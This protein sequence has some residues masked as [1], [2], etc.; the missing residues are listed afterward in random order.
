MAKTI[1]ELM[2]KSYNAPTKGKTIQELMGNAAATYTQTETTDT[3]Y[4]K[5]GLLNGVGYTLGKI[6]T[7]AFSILEG[8]WDYTAGGVA[9]IF[10]ADEWAEKQFANN[11]AAGWNQD[12]DE[13]YNPSNTMRIVGDVASGVGNSAVGLLAIAGATA[14]SGGALTAPVAGAI[15]GGVMGVGAAG[16]ATSEAYAKT[17]KLGFKEYGYG[18]LSGATEGALEGITGAAGKVGA[19]LFAKQTAKTVAK[20]TVIKGLLSDFAGEAV[21]EGLS[22]FITPYY[23]RWTQVDPNA[24]KATIQQI[25]Y[26]AL[27]GGL[28]GALMGGVGTG[29]NTVRAMSRGNEISKNKEY[30]NTVVNMAE[31][32]A[33]YEADNQTGKEAYQYVSRLVEDYKAKDN[34][35]GIL[36]LPQ[37]RILG[38]MERANAVLTFEPEIQASKDKIIADADRFAEYINSRNLVDNAGNPIN[39][40]SGADLI[41]NE[42]VLTQFAVAD[43]LG[44]LMLTPETFYS[45]VSQNRTEDVLQ[46]DFR[47]FQKN[48][49]PQ[50]KKAINEMFGVDIDSVSYEDFIAAMQKTNRDT[51]DSVQ[52]GMA[53]RASS[54][55]AFSRVNST[56]ESVGA[57]NK[58]VELKDGTS[59]YK[60]ADGKLYAVSKS[61]NNYYVYDGTNISKKLTKQ[62]LFKVVDALNGVTETT[63]ENA[64][65]QAVTQ[66]VENVSTE[67]ENTQESAKEAQKTTPTQT[68]ETK[69]ETKE[70]LKA[71]TPTKED[72]KATLAKD[73]VTHMRTL[74]KEKGGWYTKDVTNYIAEHNELDFIERIYANDPAVKKDLAGFLSAVNDVDTLEGMAWY[75]G[76]AFSDKGRTWSRTT[77]KSTYPYRGAVRTFKNAISKR[78][79]EVATG[80]NLGIQNGE[81]SLNDI[82]KLF[83]QL[84]KNP[85]IA[86]FAEKVFA[87]VERLGVNI[88]FVNATLSTRSNVAGDNAGDMVEYKTSYFNDTTV[89]D[90]KKAGTLLH[91]LVH[92]CTSY[93]MYKYADITANVASIDGRDANYVKIVNCVTRLNQIY[94]QISKDADFKDQYG[95]TNAKEMVAELANEE[96][97]GLMKKKNLWDRILDAICNLFGFTR[98]NTAYD[99]AMQCLEYILDNP[100]VYAYKDYAT[101]QR[102]KLVRSGRNTFGFTSAVSERMT[103]TEMRDTLAK[104]FDIS[105]NLG[106]KETHKKDL[107]KSYDAKNST[108]SY[109]DILGKYDKILNIWKKLGG[110]LNSK[111]LEEWDNKQGKDRTFTVFKEQAGY[112]YNIELSSM[113]KKGVPLFEAID[114]IVK[115]EV[116]KELNLKTIGKAEKEILY[117][118]LKS[119]HFEIP[120][121]ICYVEQARQREGTIIESFLDGKKETTK[122]GAVKSFKLGWNE[123]INNVQA[124]M[125]KNGVDYTFPAVDRSISTDN[126]TAQ[127][128][129]MDEATQTAFYNA[130]Q[131]LANEEIA[132][133]NKAEGKNKPLIKTVTPD[134]IKASLGGNVGSN[135]KI[136]RV[137]FQNPDS[138]FTI[139]KDL[140]YSS[141]TTLNLASS[142]NALYSLFNSQGGVAGYK[143]KQTPIVYWG[144][145]LKKTWE[146]GK[147][148]KVGGIRNQSNSDFQMYTL[149][150]QAQMYIDFTAKGYYLQAYTKVLSELKLFGLS[151][152]KINASL[153]PRV[154]AYKLANGEVDI[155]RTMATA[156]LDENGNPIY[157]DIEGIP[158]EEAFMLIDDGDYSK[159]ITGICIG[160]SDAHIEKLLDDNRV[161]LIIGFHDKTND[162]T[163]RYRGARYAKNYNGL[164]EAINN[165]T[166]KTVHI[167]FNQ[168]VQKAEKMFKYDVET[169]TAEKNMLYHNGKLYKVDNIPNLAAD[170]YLEMCKEKN[171]TPAYKDFAGHENYYKLLA[172]FG[173][174]DSKGHYAPHKKVAYNMPERVP[175]LDAN[176]Q[177][178][179]V[180]TE[181]YIKQELE[182]ELAVRDSIAQALSDTSANGIIPQFKQRVQELQADVSEQETGKD[183]KKKRNLD[184]EYFDKLI[185][186]LSWEDILGE[187]DLELYG[188]KSMSVEDTSAELKANPKKAEIYIRRTGLGK[189][190]IKDGK[191]A[192][193]KQSRIDD[194][195]EDSGAQ[196]HKTYARSYI[197]RISPKDFID[198]T[199]NQDHLDRE[200]FDKGV[201]GDHGGL[202][203]DWD[204]EK[205]L[206]DSRQSPYLHIDK[207]TGRIIGHNGR[208]RIRALEKAG[209]KAV[210]IE[211]QFYDEDGSLIKYDAETLPDV[212]ISSQFNT[213]I[214]THLYDVIP[215]NETHRA[216]I[217]STYGENANNNAEISYQERSNTKKKADLI[218]NY[219]EKQYNDFGWARANNVLTARENRNFV[220]KYGEIK[221]GQQVTVH[222]T[223][224]GEIIVETN[225]MAKDKFGVNNVLVFA[226]GDYENYQINKVIRLNLNDETSLEIVRGFIYESK[227]IV[228]ASYFDGVLEIY[229]AKDF[230]LGTQ[231]ER[232]GASFKYVETIQDGA[233]NTSSVKES[234]GLKSIDKDYLSA[235]NNG[236]MKIADRM[237]EEA[238][239]KAGYTIKAYHGSR[240]VFNAFDKTKLGSN[241]KTETSKRWFFAADKKTANSYYPY[242]VMQE[243]AKKYS[244]AKPEEVKEKG[245]LY[246]LY[247][248]MENPLTVD[249]KDYDYAAHHDKADA[250]MEFVEQAE[251]DGNDGIILLNAMDNQLDTSARESTVYMFKEPSQAKSADTVTYDENGNII[252]LSKRFDSDKPEISYQETPIKGVDNVKKQSNDSVYGF[253]KYSET[254]YSDRDSAGNQLTKEQQEFFKDSKVR[255][256]KGRLQVVYHGTTSEFNTFKRGDIG[257]HF[258][259]YAQARNR[260]SYQ[261]GKKRYIKAYLD[262]KNPLVVEHDSGS[263]HGNYAAGM[264]LTWG[265]FN[266]NP[267]AVERL[268]EIARMYDTRKSDVE[269]KSFLKSL[270]YDGVQY[271]NTH[272]SDFGKESY[273]Y[274]AFDSNQVKAVTNLNPTSD[275]DINYDI[276]GSDKVMTDLPKSKLTLQDVVLGKANKEDLV[277]QVKGNVSETTEA[278]KVL[279]TNA[280]AALERV[281]KEIGVKDATARTN[282]IRAGKYAAQNA[283]EVEGAQYNLY[284]DK[285]VGESLGKI[286]KPIYEADAKD[287]KTFADFEL[288]LLHWHNTDRYEAGKPVFNEWDDPIEQH[289]TSE[290]SRQA[291]AELEKKYPQF[292]KIAEK[293]WKF[294]DNNLQL[295]VDSG[296]YSQEYADN[297][298]E[299]YPHYVP[300]PREEYTTKAAALMGKNNL[301]VNNAKKGAKGSSARV[302][303]IDDTMSAQT[304]QKTTSARINSLLVT[305]LENGKSD[306]FQVIESEDADIDIDTETEVTFHKDEAKNTHQVSF[307]YNGKKVTAQVSRLVFKGIE[308]FRPSSGMSDNVAIAAV[309][310]VNSTF[311]KLVTSL[312]PFFSFF[313]NPVRDMQDALLYT[314]YSPL[315]FIKNYDRARKEIKTNGKYWQEAKAAGISAASVYD[316]EKG[317]EYKQNDSIS[318]AKRLKQKLESASNSIEMSPRLAEYISAREAGLSVQEALLQAQDVTTNFG[319]GGTFAKTLNSTV[320]PFLNPSIQ[321]FSKMVRSYMG[322]NGKKEWVALIIKSLI[323]G[324]GATALNDLMNDDDEEY[325]GLSDYVKEQNYL[326]GLGDGDFLKL[327]KGRVASVFGGLWLRGK[328]YAEGDEDAWNDY[329]KS[330]ASAVTPVDNFTRTIFSP[331]TDIQTNTAWHGGKIE[332]QKWDDTEPKNRYDESTSKIS[333][334]LGQVFNYSPIKIDY[335]LEQYG[336]IVADLV[337]P[338]TSTQAE[339]GIIS[340]NMLTNATLNSKW[341]SKFYS[342]LEKYTYKKTAGDLQAKAVVRYLTNI[343]STVSDMQKKK[344]EIQAS[345]T[346]SNADK[347][348]ETRII[349]AAINTLLQETLGNVEYIYKEL[350][351]YDLSDESVYDQAYYDTMNVVI[352]AGYALESYNKEVYAKA[353]SLTGLGIGYDTYYDYY[354]GLKNVSS[355]S[356]SLTKKD[357]IKYTMAQDIPTLQKIILIMSKGYK[358]KDGDIKGISERQAKTAVAKYII[359]LNISKAE[360][361]E[362][363]EMLGLTVKNGKILLNE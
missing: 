239:T 220:D 10:G 355:S 114:T 283:I 210:E 113:C 13:W 103:E 151:R 266:S 278:L 42:G 192:V 118:I 238:A 29:I 83:N 35:T 347:L 158:H 228:N 191:V 18:A 117:D 167:G 187:G 292:R 245:K 195:I 212:A 163:K 104:A 341:S 321:G 79:Q 294:N 142:H 358:I 105:E 184:D 287:G 300:T 258:G 47:N 207:T 214:E 77:G 17:G 145:I 298:R 267:E 362:L 329:A 101:E 70:E 303:P 120:C 2:S 181:E 157:D 60:T 86:K 288:Y 244:W 351:R 71:K 75:L 273:S 96:F 48:A 357:V 226:E 293:V 290:Y 110:E 250:W 201:I 311:K 90:Q 222:K 188:D 139:E 119:H 161:Q 159:N 253:D 40:A 225:D 150:D 196:F 7:G 62:E 284:G 162:G 180:A 242:G 176:G 306:E 58:A 92:A 91:E 325:E 209:I 68:T 127:N 343:N 361:T 170:L 301:A 87:T 53:A 264:L 279:T 265:D 319:R 280:Q 76:G 19:R 221:S 140:L 147:I 82:K 172:D 153:I 252:P 345:T 277:S 125:K 211:V 63:Q 97:V 327:P 330:I 333:I 352:G 5:G 8:I 72:D 129:S 243:L 14:L 268:Q 208:H 348:K 205:A 240:S 337:L 173:L 353:S 302:L 335:L 282:Y 218:D 78:I 304:I 256:S 99:N 324:I 123:V 354:F 199:V 41:K 197:T 249:V 146:S 108:V 241:T 193:M 237:V 32:F 261:G 21:E 206:K 289:I 232:S 190:H 52:G 22:E 135:F 56:N 320:M 111:F 350:G 313:K 73:F 318:K 174:K 269:L 168:Y 177:K 160:Y 344:Q 95:I 25:G 88:R 229:N 309:A 109:S 339:T 359:S 155:E 98:G 138:R 55:R 50:S 38:E 84:N 115:N 65:K 216:E 64:Q 356:G 4:N 310:K 148:R 233:R 334:W 331:F 43:A 6:G 297:L 124:E 271:L 134:A 37:K 24:E 202:M 121:A 102:G 291:V 141:M 295:A 314:H 106:Y 15:A 272:E 66:S 136:F 246:S 11:I 285:R 3:D 171:Y 27:V 122:T 67:A 20:N 154:V 247:L 299:M 227:G 231:R 213:G 44:Q 257:Y 363:A 198:L 178:Q 262:I 179:Y 259:S 234:R 89:S 217:E 164:N 81:V 30:A 182:K 203:E 322:E 149:L 80:T 116:M 112:D 349:Q 16:G 340:Q 100:D 223:S 130:L 49:S 85:D 156:G 126:Y 305:M 107:L 59:V 51:L 204:Y 28:S 342:T 31:K 166:G 286:L 270:G 254:K 315:K 1:Q 251:K 54:K 219:T 189:T 248:K 276:K 274:I 183:V 236:Y 296:M 143:S 215:L 12:L 39:F 308:A 23:Q 326:F 94:E 316:Y 230:Q 332:G 336:G 255:D 307:Y 312:N 46:S 194:A 169:G 131:K 9:D 360:K 186:E 338:A 317:I 33:K 346:L 260:L 69:V 152:G 328:R 34:G 185:E 45:V 26:S 137:L 281:L 275:P 224:N 36:T 133:Y 128:L 74:V 235:V 57:F 165:E 93:V 144:D 323:L 263:W 61:G 200:S 175:Y 132:R